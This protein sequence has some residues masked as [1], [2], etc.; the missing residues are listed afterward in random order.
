[1]NY[2]NADFMMPSNARSYYTCGVG[3]KWD[4]WTLDLSYMYAHNHMLDYSS[5]TQ[6]GVNYDTYVMNGNTPV[7]A[8]SVRARGTTHPHAHNFGIGIGYKF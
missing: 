7:L 8:K 3:F 5:S 6:E 2:G 1:M 4:N